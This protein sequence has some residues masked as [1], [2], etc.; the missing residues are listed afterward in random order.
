MQK[1]ARPDPLAI[2][3]VGAAAAMM[4]RAEGR[5][6]PRPLR[7]VG[8]V[9]AVMLDRRLLVVGALLAGFVLFSALAFVDALA[10]DLIDALYFTV[11]T[12][13]TTGYGDINLLDAPAATKAFGMIVM[14]IGSLV[15]AVVFALVTDIIVGARLAQAL[16]QFPVP[17]REHVVVCGA[18]KIGARVLEDLSRSA[19]PASRSSAT[20]TSST[21]R[22][23]SGF[24]SR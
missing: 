19:F 8:R 21:A 11:T 16:G 3:A 18:G 22:C 15:V 14:I 20:R 2:P 13:T 5:G 10:I 12:I 17:R 6:P 7:V 9:R 4:N 23:S 1:E 24:G